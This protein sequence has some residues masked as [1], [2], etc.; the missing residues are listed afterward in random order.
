[1]D[2]GIML[3]GETKYFAYK[4]TQNELNPPRTVFLPDTC[5]KSNPLVCPPYTMLPV[6]PSD[7]CHKAIILGDL[8]AVHNTCEMVVLKTDDP[9]LHP[10]RI[11]RVGSFSEQASL[12]PHSL[13][14]P[15]SKNG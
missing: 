4:E 3:A 1:M 10:N 7:L 2:Q 9:R 5:I 8:P 12:H 14:N 15:V 11:L 13:S 6:T